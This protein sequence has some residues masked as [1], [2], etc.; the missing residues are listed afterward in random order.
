MTKSEA[1]PGTWVSVVMMLVLLLP[2]AIVGPLLLYHSTLLPMARYFDTLSWEEA[3]CAIVSSRLVE[4]PDPADQLYTPDIV[5]SYV[6]EGQVYRSDRISFSGVKA[7]VPEKNAQA[8]LAPYPSGGRTI[9][10][11]DPEDPGRAVLDPGISMGSFGLGL[12]G[13][14]LTAMGVGGLGFVFYRLRGAIKGPAAAAPKAP[15]PQRPVPAGGVM[16]AELT[17]SPGRLERLWKHALLALVWNGVVAS[18]VWQVY[19]NLRAERPVT[20]L[21]WVLLPLALAGLVLLFLAVR[22]LLGF[23]NPLPRLVLSPAVPVRGQTTELQWWLTGSAARVRRLRI[24]LEGRKARRDDP[25]ESTVLVDATD[26]GRTGAGQVSFTLPLGA[27]P[28]V[29]KL[30]VATEVAAGPDFVDNFDVPVK[31]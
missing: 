30:H 13:L 22:R 24:I 16:P 7:Y 27:I 3:P 6:V 5:F 12:L 9:C 23:F 21:A 14:V 17:P 8:S 2:W 19:R 25:F 10:Y 31:L 4:S 15:K 29:W 11:Y 28:S 18:F 20:V 26:P 1:Q